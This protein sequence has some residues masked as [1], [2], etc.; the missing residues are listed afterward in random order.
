M[1]V[2]RRTQMDVFERHAVDA[3]IERLAEHV[4]RHFPAVA[5]ATSPTELRRILYEAKRLAELR[6]PL[7]EQSL[8]RY[9]NVAVCH[10]W[11]FEVRFAWAQSYLDDPGVPSPNERIARLHAEVLRR[12]ERAEAS[13]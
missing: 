3:L 7:S 9:V 12:M 5:R 6:G 1:L 4:A 13:E 8:Y 2:I 11:D 10:G